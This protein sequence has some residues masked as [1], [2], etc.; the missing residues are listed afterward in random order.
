MKTGTRRT[1]LRSGAV[2][3]ALPWLESLAAPG[4]EVAPRRLV[5]ICTDFGLYGP[6]FFPEQDGRGYEPS[7]YLDLLDG[8]R[9]SFTV[10]SGISHPDVGGDHASGAC[11][12]TSAPHVSKAGFRN[13][14]SVDFLAAQHVGAATRFPLLSLST[15]NGSPLTHTSSGAG[16]SAI[17]KPSDVFARLF[18]AGNAEATQK[19][20]QRLRNGQSILD[21]M[22]DRFGQLRGRLSIDD[23]RQV[24]GYTEA[25]RDM[26]KQLVADEA[27]VHRPKPAVDMA[28]PKEVYPSPF[29]DMSD[30]VGRARVMLGIVRLAL[31]TDSTRVVSLFIR[32]AEGK[33]PIEGVSEGHH[34]L[35]HHGQDPSIIEQL[36]I[37]E[38][39]EMAVFKEF[40]SGLQETSDAGQS[41]LDCTQ[42]LIGSNLGD[43]SSHNTTNLPVLLAGGGLRHGRHIKG[44]PRANTPLANLF[45]TMLQRFGVEADRFG[46]SNGAFGE[47]L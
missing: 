10:F 31:Q 5:C 35:T 30:L 14:I 7:E 28:P 38:R 27:W 32:G 17:E 2:G 23:Q 8:L 9:D 16:I 4:Q 3:L 43:A 42:V 44:D 12:L 41:L 21:R 34:R 33:P 25:V 11:F 37:V 26:E 24:E 46:S 36:R 29:S 20:L 13:S 40:L 45:V 22:A 19:E 39:Q 15:A 47:L 18:L 1:F 6:S